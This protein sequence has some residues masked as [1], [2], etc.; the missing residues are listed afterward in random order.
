MSRNFGFADR[1]PIWEHIPEEE[2]LQNR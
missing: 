2:T 1:I